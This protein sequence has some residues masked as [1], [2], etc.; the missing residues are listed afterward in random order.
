MITKNLAKP[1][2]VLL[3]ALAL[4][5]CAKKDETPPTKSGKAGTPE[6]IR[7][8]NTIQ[9]TLGNVGGDL[10]LPAEVR[11]RF[12]QRYAF[13]V[14]G[15]IA[16]RKV[17]VGQV[18]SAGQVLAIMDS[19][20]VM[21]A[22]AAQTAQV[23]AAKTDTTLQQ[24][25]LKRVQEL[26]SKGF[27][28]TAALDRQ[29]A[30]TDAAVARLKAA[31]SQLASVQNNL[32]F[33]TL[34]ADK[35]GVV[36]SVEADASAVVAAGQTVVRVA[37]LGEKE[38]VVSVPEKQIK[39]LREAT[40]IVAV[41]EAVSGKVYGA[42]LRELAP[43]AD[44]ASRTYLARLSLLNP[45]ENLRLGMSASV[46]I[47][48]GQQQSI[49][50]PNTALYTRDNIARVWVVD[51]ATETVRA[52][53]VQLGASTDTGVVIAQGLKVGDIVVTAGANL[54][55]EGQKVRLLGVRP[56]AGQS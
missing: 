20:D 32:N 39:A 50:V 14:N 33:Q 12:E 54:L 6:V 52:V 34:K 11:P 2:T 48:L 45:D 26:S 44:P 37:Q 15:K 42:K 53:D 41:S 55:L 47:G 38:L 24:A 25:E 36:T 16:Q 17:E 43:T 51:K 30:S 18:V 21:P 22:I 35:A 28:S 1:V 31:Q 27:L 9:V 5:A 3:L 23:E 40:Q 49:T 46:R 4:S 8:V 29:K 7:P 13:R 10:Y 19:S 56:A